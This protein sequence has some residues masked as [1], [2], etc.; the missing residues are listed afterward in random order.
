M[1]AALGGITLKEN[2]TLTILF[3]I[4]SGSRLPQSDIGKESDPYISVRFNAVPI[5]VIIIVFTNGT[6]C[7]ILL[8][9]NPAK[10][11]LLICRVSAD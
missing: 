4:C 3:D 2:E 10:L 7:R 5:L 8:A 1:D 11:L 9:N 6:Y